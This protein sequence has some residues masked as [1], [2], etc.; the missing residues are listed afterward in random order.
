M[1]PDY[2]TLVVRIYSSLCAG[3]LHAS[4]AA[5]FIERST[6]QMMLENMRRRPATSSGS[7]KGQ[8]EVRRARC[9]QIPLYALCVHTVHAHSLHRDRQHHTQHS[10]HSICLSGG[11]WRSHGSPIMAQVG[12]L[13]RLGSQHAHR[14]SRTPGT[15][16]RRDR[17][18]GTGAGG[19]VNEH[20]LQR[21]REVEQLAGGGQG[22]P[23]TSSLLE[24]SA[25]RGVPPVQVAKGVC[26]C[27]WPGMPYPVSSFR[28]AVLV[29]SVHKDGVLLRFSRWPGVHVQAWG[30]CVLHS[31]HRSLTLGWCLRCGTDL[32]L[33]GC[34]TA[35]GA[36]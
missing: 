1:M 19:I 32:L 27:T 36:T 31:G 35:A 12:D 15:P 17:A 3:K 11:S 10:T 7:S 34:F 24:V 26:Q 25:T 18:P 30:G 14:I 8:G 6:T 29:L 9:T 4:M 2:S 21:L 13:T 22:R 20:V 5:D 28:R 16:L 33:S 23:L